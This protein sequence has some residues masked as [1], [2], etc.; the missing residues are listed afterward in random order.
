MTRG[1]EERSNVERRGA[2][3]TKEEPSRVFAETRGG[4]EAASSATDVT[5]TA[6]N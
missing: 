5:G 6:T 4:K 2:T 1:K 3:A